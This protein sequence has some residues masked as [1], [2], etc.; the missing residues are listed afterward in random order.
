MIGRRRPHNLNLRPKEWDKVVDKHKSLDQDLRQI[1][2][3]N[4]APHRL[5]GTLLEAGCGDGALLSRLVDRIGGVVG[6]DISSKACKISALRVKNAH[7]LQCDL[8]HLPFQNEIFDCIFMIDTIE[9]LPQPSKALKEAHRTMK[10][11]GFLILTTPNGFP[12]CLARIEDK[13]KGKKSPG[14]WQPYDQLLSPQQLKK[15]LTKSK[16][17]IMK[18]IGYSRRLSVVPFYQFL[19]KM[20]IIKDFLFSSIAVIAQKPTRAPVY[21]SNNSTEELKY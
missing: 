11:R 17:Q 6:V 7:V 4:L 1:T 15:L 3:L 2:A 20:P 16:I 13:F 10:N 14:E 19:R 5:S 18:M 21:L 9:H 12:I 8:H